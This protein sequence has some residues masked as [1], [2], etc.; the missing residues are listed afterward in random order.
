MLFG[1]AG[2]F[3]KQNGEMSTKEKNSSRSTKMIHGVEVTRNGYA[4]NVQWYTQKT[5]GVSEYVL[6]ANPPCV[7]T[8]CELV[9]A[10]FDMHQL[11][12]RVTRVPRSQTVLAHHMDI[13]GLLP[14]R[15]NLRTTEGDWYRREFGNIWQMNEHVGDKAMEA[16]GML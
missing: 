14:N 10:D 7:K 11:T 12:G 9:L 2:Q 8:N 15:S 13:F 3:L 16:A 1:L 6:D 5:I 4:I